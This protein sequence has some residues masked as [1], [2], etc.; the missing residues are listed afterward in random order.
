MEEL[1]AQTD[2]IIATAHAGFENEYGN[3]GGAEA[4]IEKFPEIP[5]LLVGHSHATVSEK[6]GQTAVGGARDA[7]RQVVRFDLKLKNENDQWKVVDNTVEIIEVKEYE[8]SEDLKEYA[9][10]YHEKNFRFSSRGNRYCNRGF[11]ARV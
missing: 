4:I 5:A 8:A 1:K 2:I 7:G 3:D 11:C 9:K 10:E 6:Y